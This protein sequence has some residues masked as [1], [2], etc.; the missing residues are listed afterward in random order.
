MNF[1]TINK[2]F[3]MSSNG[4]FYGLHEW[5]VRI[6]NPSIRRHEIGIVSILNPYATTG[7]RTL[8]GQDMSICDM[9]EFGAR[10]VYGS[11]CQTFYY[12]S[13]NENNF[14]RCYKQLNE[15]HKYSYLNEGDIVKVVLDLYKG[16]VAFYLNNKK[17]KSTVNIQKSKVYYPIISYFGRFRCELVHYQ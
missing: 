16:N 11:D 10:T 5:S 2:D 3:I 17:I 6:I 4:F 7:G 8:Q 9:E 15:Y 12:A 13:Y 1:N 14:E